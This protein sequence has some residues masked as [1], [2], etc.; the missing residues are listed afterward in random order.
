[1]NINMLRA[2]VYKRQIPDSLFFYQKWQF[3]VEMCTETEK[4]Q[5]KSAAWRFQ[6]N[7]KNFQEAEMNKYDSDLK[8]Q[9]SAYVK[10]SVLNAKGHYLKKKCR[11]E[12]IAVSYTHLQKLMLKG[13]IFILL[14]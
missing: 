1:M 4:M 9:F 6:R 8:T 14:L 3:S 2:D 11:I 10:Q 5:D 12:C 7:R 13:N